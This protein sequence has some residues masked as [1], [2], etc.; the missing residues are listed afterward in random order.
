[1]PS[2]K[3]ATRL[4]QANRNRHPS[5]L[6]PFS[7]AQLPLHAGIPVLMI[8]VS[9][10]R[11]LTFILILRCVDARRFFGIP[12]HSSGFFVCHGLPL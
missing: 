11:T 4:N 8:L 10:R 1:M 2:G 5:T 9:F 7:M 3:A 12:R 6:H